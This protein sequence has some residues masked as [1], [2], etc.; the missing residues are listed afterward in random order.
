MQINRREFLK[1]MG[2]GAA[3]LALSMFGFSTLFKT[4]NNNSGIV[5]AQSSG[6]WDAPINQPSETSAIHA[7]LIS[8][9][10]VFWLSGSGNYTAWAD[11]PF[12]HGIWNPNGSFSSTDTLGEDLFCCG[13]NMLANG[14]VLLAGGTIDYDSQTLNGKWHGGKFAYEVDW[15]SGSVSNRTEMAHGRWY[16]TQITL[17]DGKVFVCQGLDEYGVNNRLVEFYDPANRSWQIRLDPGL[18]TTWC[19]GVGEE[20]YYPDAGKTCY[21]P[22]TAPYVTLYPRMHLMPNGLIASVGAGVDDRVYDPNTFRWVFRGSTIVRHYGTS[23]LC[24]LENTTTERGKILVCGGSTPRAADPATASAQIAEPSGNGL[25]RRN[26]QSMNSARKHLNPV[27]LPTGQIGIFGG[28]R[29]GTREPVLSPEVFDPVSETWTVWPAASVAR[30]YHGIA[31]LLQDGR[32]WTAGSTPNATTKEIRVEIFNPWYSSETRPTISSDPTGGAYGGTITIPTPDA[33]NIT[34]VSLVRVSS[35]THHYNTDQRLIWLQI[36]STTSSSVT[37]SAPINNR[38]APAGY[39]LVHILN[40]AGVPSVGRF[41]RIP[42]SA[43]NPP[44]P[45]EGN[46]TSIYSVSATGSSLTNLNTGGL[47]RVGEWMH[48]NA[49]YNS[50]LIG[51]PVKRVNVIMRRA[52]NATG[53][54]SVVVRRFSDDSIVHTFGTIDAATL[55]TLADQTFTFESASP[56]TLAVN[57]RVL[58]E[59]G[60]TGTSTDQVRVRK[61][62]FSDTGGFDGQNTKWVQYATAYAVQNFYD[63]VGEWFKLETTGS[64]TTAPTV[65]ITS[66]ANGDTISGPSTGVTVNVAG[67]ASDNSGGSGIQKVEVQVGSANPFRLATATGTGGS[68][69][70]WSASDVVT[71]AGDHTITA[72]ATDNAGNT[73]DATITVTVAFSGGGG[74][75]TSIYSVSAVGSSLANLNTGGLRRVGEWMHRSATYNSS[76]IGQP[77]KRVNVIMRRAGNATGTISVVVRRFSDDSIVHTFGTRDAATLSTLADQTFTF[78]SASPYTLAV[79]DRVLVEWGGTGTSTDQVRVRKSP[80]SDTGGF[81]GQNTKWVQYATGYGVQNFYDLVGEWFSVS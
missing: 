38:L 34:K 53:T 76:L 2:S 25:T 77:V 68:W 81:D 51:Q 73:R 49:T 54:I 64:D 24:P 19:A 5:S 79:N 75:Y 47:R 65:S 63:L 61:S 50:S 56:Y 44:P 48:R 46:Y 58:V 72:R 30:N 52:G 39:Y 45:D 67:T 7:A 23:V 32:V 69:S 71:T 11:G 6:S 59:W 31:L 10:R 74:T 40:S 62:P 29:I 8:G 21:G 13:M 9:G 20:L 78:E 27:I 41:I 60:G 33:A 70:T 80:F 14:N 43:D 22:G 17:P 57:D 15:S 26:V 42:G 35:T 37:V 66:P 1:L 36:V 18:S 28:N 3:G 55:S 4:Q 12:Y 16:P